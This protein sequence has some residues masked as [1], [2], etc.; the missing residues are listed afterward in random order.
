MSIASAMYRRD[1]RWD[2]DQNNL[3]DSRLDWP[4]PG[5]NGLNDESPARHGGA[6]SGRNADAHEVRGGLG[7]EH[8]ALADDD[9][10][11]DDD[12]EDGEDHHAD[13][14]DGRDGSGHHHHGVVKEEDRSDGPSNNSGTDLAWGGSVD[15]FVW[16]DDFG[17]DGGENHQPDMS[18]FSAGSAVDEKPDDARCETSEVTHEAFVPAIAM[19]HW[20]L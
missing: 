8:Q 5:P 19:E 3:D 11:D 4:D 9:H 20:L 17:R 18:A 7:H 15:T 12:A 13:G 6:L 2:G 1:R 14:H 10:Q 16:T